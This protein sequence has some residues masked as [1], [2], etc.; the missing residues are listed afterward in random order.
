MKHLILPLIGVCPLVAVTLHVDET[1]ASSGD[2]S[3]WASAF[4]NL[5]EAFTVAVS[6]DVVLVAEG[7]YFP[8]EGPTAI[9]N[10]RLASFQLVEGVE[11]EGGYPNGGGV[12]DLSSHQTVLSGDLE[13]DDDDGPSGLNSYNVVLASGTTAATILDGF[14]IS[15]GLAD[16]DSVDDFERER[17]G[18]GLFS[19]GGS[20]TIINCSFRANVGGF[21]GA[22]FLLTRQLTRWH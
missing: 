4:Q 12:R 7:V 3:S 22:C 9:D 13:Q 19:S 17:S 5:Q 6:G 8:D 14:L 2:G 20:P 21:G 11:V 16:D 1:V 10:D 18:G 15:G